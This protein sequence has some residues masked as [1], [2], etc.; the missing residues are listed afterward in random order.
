MWI[1][2]NSN[3]KLIIAQF[4]LTR[5]K[6]REYILHELNDPVRLFQ[7]GYITNLLLIKVVT[8]IIF[9]GGVIQCF[10]AAQGNLFLGK[11]F[12]E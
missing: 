11:T 3:A 5:T 6:C 10:S 12:E 1:V 2:T 8:V 7:N 9:F 4:H